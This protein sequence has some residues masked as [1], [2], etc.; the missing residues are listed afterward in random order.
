MVHYSTGDWDYSNTEWQL[1]S[2]IY[3]SPPSSFQELGTTRV[4]VRTTTVGIDKVK[5]GRLVSYFRMDRYANYVHFLLRWQ[6]VNNKYRVRFEQTGTGLVDIYI[7]KVK[8]GVVTELWWGTKSWPTD[9]WRK[10]RVTWWNDYV[11]LVIRVEYWDGENWVIIHDAYDSEN[12]WKD[13]GGRVGFDIHS[14]AAELPSFLDDTE[15]W[16][17]W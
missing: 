17:L 2:T 5:E 13:T 10:I 7:E 11:G 16:G 12:L 8:G 6:D 4:L 9:V 15:I 14:Y 3:V 1:S